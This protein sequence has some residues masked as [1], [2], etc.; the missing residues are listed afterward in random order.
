LPAGHLWVAEMVSGA[1]Q[2]SGRPWHFENEMDCGRSE[3]PPMRTKHHDRYSFRQYLVD[4]PDPDLRRI[5]H[6]TTHQ[7]RPSRNSEFIDQKSIV[8]DLIRKS[9]TVQV[10]HDDLVAT[11]DE[12]AIAYSTVMKYLREEQINLSL[13]VARN[14]RSTV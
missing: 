2:D 1:E 3:E 11:L 6:L 12:Q 10:I 4:E 9:W 14:A 7:N 8:L 13:A 5:L